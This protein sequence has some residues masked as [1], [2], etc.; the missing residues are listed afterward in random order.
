MA[1][2][3]PKAEVKTKPRLYAI[4]TVHLDTQW[5]WTIQDTI[6]DFIPAT[7]QRNFDLLE[8]Y[9]FFVVSFE[10]AFRYQLMQEYY[11]ED[12]E[13]LRRWVSD[14]RWRVAGSML[15]SPDVNA[16]SPESLIRQILY[17]NGFFR[18]ELGLD[19]CDIFLPDCFGFGHALPSVAAHCGLL[20]FSAQKFGRWM[21]PAEIP[22]DVGFWQGP[23]GNG[24]VAAIRPGGYGEGLDEDLSRAPRLHDRLNATGKSCGTAVGIRYVGVGD[25]G[26]GLDEA[27]MRWL[28]TSVHGDGPVEVVLSGSDQ[29]FRDLTSDQVATMPRHADELL[30]PTHGTGCLTSQ[31]QLKRWNRHNELLADA[32]ERAAVMA[33]SY[34]TLPYPADRLRQAWTRFLWHQMHDDLT[35]TS[36]PAAYQFTDNDE[37]LSLNQFAATLTQSIGALAASMD[38]RCSGR[39]LVVFNPLSIARQDV[40]T[41]DLPPD[42]DPA[43]PIS[44]FGPEGQEIAAQLTTNLLGEPAVIFLAS[45]PALGL[46]VFDIRSGGAT[47]LHSSELRVS[48]TSISNHRYRVR[49]N[50]LG[51]VDSVF[52]TSRERELLEAPIQL[53]LIRDRSARWPAWEILYEDLLESDPDAVGGPTEVRIVEKGP[54]RVALAMTRTSRRSRFHQIVRLAAE[55][56]GDRVEIVNLVH[57]R[58]RGRLLKACFNLSSSN[59]LATYDLGLGTIQRGNNRREKYEVPAQQWAALT[60]SAGSGGVSILNDCKYGWDK[61]DDRTLRLSLLRSPRVIRKFRHQGT[62]DHGWHRFNLGL[63]GHR[64]TWNAADSSWQAARMNQPL[65]AFTTSNHSGPLGRELSLLDLDTNRVMLQTLKLSESG[66]RWVARLREL[67]GEKNTA[68]IHLRRPVRAAEQLNGME[69]AIGPA[70]LEGERLLAEFDPFSLR[71]FGLEVANPNGGVAAGPES[72]QVELPFDRVA[73]R[74]RGRTD[75]RGFDG[76][77][78]SIPAEIWPRRLQYGG[79]E[80]GLGSGTGDSCNALACRGQQIELGNHDF[81]HLHLLAASTQD[82]MGGTFGFGNTSTAIDIGFYSGFLGRRAQRRSLLRP[83]RSGPPRPGNH[84]PVAWVGTHRLDEQGRAEPYVFCYLFGY[85]LEIPAGCPWI[86]L[87]RA[88]AIHIFAMVLTNSRVG[89]TRPARALYD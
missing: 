18:E 17:G 77:G 49:V 56:P 50:S 79:V 40:V 45:M 8:R 41:F 84:L 57:W 74:H 15:D 10:G 23:D 11:P 13:T 21:A 36:I 72:R 16:V 81:D 80:F 39:P 78:H 44:V 19:S 25:R 75:T 83:G 52:D 82:R 1:E 38:T 14:G 54:V 61:P 70:T 2:N 5:R 42:F 9:P 34:G 12:F 33:A 3:R 76:K 73:T 47:P 20:G 67:S 66:N 62:Q 64:D 30:L 27:S 24:I 63:Y 28:D 59:S 58:T 55:N 35:G 7:L 65:M 32:A 53:Q 22:F 48:P 60:D 29:I 68:T 51:D 31:A 37:L 26:G 88:E 85:A 87:P 46:R 6:R 43:V 86:E 4:A 71:S 89:D 69:E